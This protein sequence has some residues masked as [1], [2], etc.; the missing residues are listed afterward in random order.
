MEY[1]SDD[2]NY[3][4]WRDLIDHSIVRYSIQHPSTRNYMVDTR[5]CHERRLD[6]VREQIS[7]LELNQKNITPIDKQLCQRFI[8]ERNSLEE[9]INTQHSS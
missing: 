1:Y 2:D 9:K 6:F 5:S 8:E 4:M 3:D 7:K